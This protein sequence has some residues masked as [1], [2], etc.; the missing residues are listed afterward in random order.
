M[1]LVM[2]ISTYKLHISHNFEKVDK[3]TR[4]SQFWRHLKQTLTFIYANA[5]ST[6]PKP[7]ATQQPRTCS[8]NYAGCELQL[9]HQVPKLWPPPTYDSFPKS[10]SSPPRR[11]EPPLGWAP[12]LRNP[13]TAMAT[14]DPIV[15]PTSPLTWAPSSESRVFGSVGR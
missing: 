9:L 5:F 4:P 10:F 7:F 12:L 11:R 6:C 14:G 13:Q 2:F 3:Q 8:G 15:R 1:P